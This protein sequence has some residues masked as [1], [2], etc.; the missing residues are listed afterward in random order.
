MMDIVKYPIFWNILRISFA[1]SRTKF[2]SNWQQCFCFWYSR[3]QPLWPSQIGSKKQSTETHIDSFY[4]QRIFIK[5]DYCILFHLSIEFRAPNRLA[6]SS[7]IWPL[8]P[9]AAWASSKQSWW[10]TTDMNGVYV[11]CWCLQKYP[12]VDSRIPVAV[13]WTW[14][15]SAPMMEFLLMFRAMVLERTWGYIH[16]WILSEVSKDHHDHVTDHISS[17]IYYLTWLHLKTWL[18]WRRGLCVSFILLHIF[19]PVSLKLSFSPSPKLPASKPFT[20]SCHP[21]HPKGWTNRHR[22]GFP[23]PAAG[24]LWMVGTLR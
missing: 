14:Q 18:T 19:H 24:L 17:I 9:L 8:R 7:H 16:C 23:R 2:N 10:S 22:R 3:Y 21:R 4:V 12:T 1:A 6:L 20:T 5:I 15:A 11:Y 13:N